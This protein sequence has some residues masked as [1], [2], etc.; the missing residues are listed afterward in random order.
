MDDADI[1]DMFAPLGD[2]A[3]KRLFSGK[4]IYHRG[5][6]VGA[7][8]DGDL[9]LKGDAES[10]PDFLAAGSTQWVYAYPDGRTIKM[11][12]WSMPAEAMDDPDQR[13]TWVKLAYAAALRSDKPKRPA[14]AKRT[15]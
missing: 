10:E 5:L 14:S 2:V 15:R 7:V 3:V 6:I 9:L 13:A 12:Y 8:M 4:G 1:K 11:P